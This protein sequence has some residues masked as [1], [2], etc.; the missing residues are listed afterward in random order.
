MRR[1][2]ARMAGGSIWAPAM[3]RAEQPGRMGWDWRE[4]KQK[5]GWTSPAAFS[6]TGTVVLPAP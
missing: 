6:A 2:R 4:C 3:R 5:S 1:A